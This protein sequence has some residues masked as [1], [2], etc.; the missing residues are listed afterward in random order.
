M[1]IPMRVA[2]CG[3]SGS[4]KTNSIINLLKLFNGTF[5]TISI[6]TK[7][8]DEPL[9]KY[10]LDVYKKT[11]KIGEEDD[12]TIDDDITKLKKINDYDETKNHLII[13]DDFINDINKQITE[14][15]IRG[16]KKNISIIFIVQSYYINNNEWK[17]IRRN[18][19]YII[20]KKINSSKELITII[21]D[22]S[23]DISK[24]KFLKMYEDI[25][26]DNKFN[27]LMLDLDNSDNGRFR[28]NFNEVIDINKLK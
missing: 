5:D 2:V 18:L 3:G 17:L 4:G 23:L 19:N 8:T 15:F 20:I 27:F 9:Y 6:Y 10:L 12:L 26:K 22:Y 1:K 11:H 14:L 13:I 7:Q 25:T 16:R 24:E 28:K 21:K